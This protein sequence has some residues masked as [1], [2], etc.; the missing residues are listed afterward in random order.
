MTTALLSPW[1]YFY[2][3]TFYAICPFCG[4]LYD[5]C[6]NWDSPW[7]LLPLF[8]AKF[9][10]GSHEC[11][12]PATAIKDL[13]QKLRMRLSSWNQTS[14]LRGHEWGRVKTACSESGWLDVLKNLQE[15]SFYL[16]WLS[17]L[18]QHHLHKFSTFIPSREVT[19]GPGKR[20]CQFPCLCKLEDSG[21]VTPWTRY[22]ALTM[23]SRTP[24]GATWDFTACQDK[25]QMSHYTQ[26]LLPSAHLTWILALSKLQSSS[27]IEA[28]THGW[29]DLS[30]EKGFGWLL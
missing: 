9:L 26:T 14:S 28:E 15:W 11:P 22:K 23:I 25:A 29:K 16:T 30:S 21:L 10:T 19:A 24:A 12:S 17:H 13:L 8:A 2:S 20:L 27:L 6:W 5:S 3:Q 7:L 18:S 4:F 1:Y